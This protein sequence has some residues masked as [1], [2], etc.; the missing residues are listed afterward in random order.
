MVSFYL[1]SGSFRGV[2]S[3]V[4]R[5]EFSLENQKSPTRLFTSGIP[6]DDFLAHLKT[7]L[8]TQTSANYPTSLTLKATPLLK[9]G[10]ETGLSLPFII[11]ML[12]IAGYLPNL[13]QTD[14][15]FWLGEIS[16]DGEIL[17]LRGVL[18]IVLAARKQGLNQAYVPATSAKEATLATGVTVYPIT[19]LAQLLAHLQGE[20]AISPLSSTRLSTSITPGIDLA[21]IRGHWHVKRVMEIAATGGHSLLLRGAPGVGKTL[22]AQ[23]FSSLLP[24]MTPEEQC[25]VTS[26]YSVQGLLTQS[27]PI[28]TKRP[29]CELA[30]TSTAIEAVG[31]NRIAG[32]GKLALAHHGALLLDNLAIFKPSVIKA[33]SLALNQHNIAYWAAKNRHQVTIPARVQ[34]VATM[35]PCPCGFLHDY[36]HLC[37]CTPEKRLQYSQRV[38]GL[39]QPHLDLV[40]EVPRQEDRMIQSI[41]PEESSAQVRERVQSTRT[42][43]WQRFAG[44]M[45]TCNA[46]MGQEEIEQYCF[47]EKSGQTMMN[48]AIKELSLDAKDTRKLLRVARTIADLAARDSIAPQ[49]LAE[50]ILYYGPSP[51]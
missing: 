30:P 31:G 47:L 15:S 16:L 22:L 18:P 19:S 50:A 9:R 27:H 33:L 37:R 4:I 45:V 35:L 5:L 21:T 28:I 14:K 29:F 42:T 26:R 11:G 40:V 25:E 2:E 3:E 6:H 23:A 32:Y 10:M 12:A 34:L 24:T 44:T 51:R 17:P 41:V 8:V 39:L 36:E 38:P 48:T 1:W 20:Q 7:L 49:H 46:E 43:Q 13:F